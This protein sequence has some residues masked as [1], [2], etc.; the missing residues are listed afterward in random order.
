MYGHNI[1]HGSLYLHGLICCKYFEQLIFIV[2][3]VWILN[4]SRFIQFY[5]LLVY[6]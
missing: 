5:K 1:Y 4:V 3:I 6:F 2:A